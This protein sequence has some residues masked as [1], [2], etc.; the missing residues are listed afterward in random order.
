MYMYK[1]T[2]EDEIFRKYTFFAV[3]FEIEVFY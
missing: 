2:V 3:I 1:Q